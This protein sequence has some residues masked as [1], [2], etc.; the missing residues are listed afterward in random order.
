MSW[1]RLAWNDHDTNFFFQTHPPNLSLVWDEHHCFSLWMCSHIFLSSCTMYLVFHV[2]S[3]VA[4]NRPPPVLLL[5]LSEN[6][7]EQEAFHS[8]QQAITQVLRRKHLDRFLPF[9]LFLESMQS[10]IEVLTIQEQTDILVFTDPHQAPSFLQNQTR[11]DEHHFHQ[12]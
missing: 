4:S 3:Y 1:L 11:L 6:V 5:C 8:W 7:L 2:L 10:F 12:E 9:Y